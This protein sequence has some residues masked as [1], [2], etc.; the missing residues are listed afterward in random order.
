MTF[1]DWIILAILV[2]AVLGGFAQG[3]LR[4]V[5]SLGGLVLGLVLGAW[6]YPRAAVMIRHMV[7]STELANA[8]GFLVIA[9]LVAVIANLL[10]HMVSKVFQTLG[11]GCL[12]RLAGGVFGFFQGTLVVTVCILVTVA[13]FPNAEWLTRSRLSRYFFVACH[14]STHVSPSMLADHVR[15][16]LNHLERDSPA[17]MHPENHR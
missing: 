1:V 12:D 6:N 4:S 16:D 15:E 7:P 13:F 8:V 10:G 5:F 11:L 3:F 9:L 17:W 14:I 2:C